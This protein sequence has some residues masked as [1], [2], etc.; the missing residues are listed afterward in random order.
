V[1]S[2][3][4]RMNSIGSTPS[5]AVLRTLRDWEDRFQAFYVLKPHPAFT[6]IED[7]TEPFDPTR[8]SPIAAVE[9]TLDD[10]ENIM[11]FVQGIAPADLGRPVQSMQD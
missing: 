3:K 1:V 10:L 11:A 7:V 6:Q 2:D 8:P 4:N 9:M 5:F